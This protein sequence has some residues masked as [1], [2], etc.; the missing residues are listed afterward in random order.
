VTSN[1]GVRVTRHML[2][3]ICSWMNADAGYQIATIKDDTLILQP[4]T[5]EARETLESDTAEILKGLEDTEGLET[6]E[7]DSYAEPEE[8]FRVSDELRDE[9]GKEA[10][11]SYEFEDERDEEDFGGEADADLPVDEITEFDVEDAEESG[12]D[13]DRLLEALEPNCLERLKST[14]VAVVGGGLAGLMAARRLGHHGIKSTVFEARSQLGGRVLSNKTFSSGRITEEGAELI[15]SFHTTWLELAWQYGLAVISRMDESLYERTYMDVKVTLDRPLRMDENIALNKQ[16]I[17]QVLRPMAKLASKINDPSKP[18]LEPPNIKQYDG[19]SVAR[20]LEEFYKVD[21]KSQLWKLIELR[22]VN[23]EVA[24]LKEM[25]FLG[26]L[27]KVK[28]A[29]I[30]RFKSDRPDDP[31]GPENVDAHLMRY[32]NELEIFRCADGCQK[33]AEELANGIKHTAKILK[34]RAVTNIELS[35]KGVV[36]KHKQV[37]DERKGTLANGAPL[38]QRFDYVILAIPPSVWKGVTITVDGKDAKLDVKPGLVKMGDA[39]KYFSDLK[40]RFWIKK[41]A[42]PLGGSLTLGQVWEG[43]DNQTRL[44][45]RKGSPVKENQGIVLSVFAGPILAGPRAPTKADCHR[46]LKRLFPE[47]TANFNKDL[48]T[49]W[50]NIPFIKTGYAA[51]KIGEFLKIGEELSKPFHDVLFFAGEHTQMDFFGYMEGALRSGKRAAENLIVHL[52]AEPGKPVIPYPNPPGARAEVEEEW[53]TSAAALLN[54]TE[55]TEDEE[56]EG[57]ETESG[58]PERDDL[59]DWDEAAEDRADQRSYLTNEDGQ[60]LDEFEEETRRK[61]NP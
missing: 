61:V 31:K 12:I 13:D 49:D 22:F 55:E 51:P 17:F 27:C 6:D 50:P 46:E 59:R 44:V 58:E 14:H 34:S 15:G 32:W 29:Q 60:D 35:K 53:E 9:Y 40:E 24:P 25:N 56:T 21:P 36:L 57:Q 28:A 26:L 48:F 4:R 1:L 19:W 42:A 18:W 45:K 8:R 33:L 20:A 30:I 54:E 2:R 23:T 39:V 7:S 47:Y 11:E 3:E 10:E 43:T 37:L 5:K 16:M 52:C 41:K 38:S